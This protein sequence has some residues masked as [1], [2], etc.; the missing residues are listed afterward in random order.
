MKVSVIIGITGSNSPL[1]RTRESVRA[2]VESARQKGIGCSVTEVPANLRDEAI[3]ASSGKYVAWVEGGDLISSN[4][5]TECVELLE[6]REGE[7]LLLHPE[8]SILFGQ[9]PPQ[10]LRSAD[11]ESPEFNPAG[12]VWSN[13]WSPLVLAPRALLLE[14]PFPKREPGFGHETWHWNCELLHR[15]VIHKAVPRTAHFLRLES[16]HVGELLSRDWRVPVLPSEYFA[17]PLAA[18]RPRE[19][20]KPFAGSSW[21]APLCKESS[22]PLPSDEVHFDDGALTPIFQRFLDEIGPNPDCLFVMHQLRRG[23]AELEAI[24]HAR[25]FREVNPGSRV[26]FVTTELSAPDW[27]DHLPRGMKVLPLGRETIQYFTG[28][29]QLR[30]LLKLLLQAR[31][32]AIH[33]KHSWQCWDLFR[34]CNTALRRFSRLFAS[35]YCIEYAQDGTKT[36]FAYSHLAYCTPAL[37]AVFCDNQSLADHLRDE[38]G[39][40]SARVLR[41]PVF[42]SSLGLGQGPG[43]P[44][45][46]GRKLRVLWASRLARQKNLGVLFTVADHMREDEFHVYGEFSE[47]PDHEL[48]RRLSSTPN[49]HYFGG[50]DGLDSIATESF[51]AFL[52][53][54]SWDGLPNILLEAGVKGLPVLAPSVGGIPELIGKTTGFPVDVPADYI[55]ALEEIRAN[56]TE[57]DRRSRNLAALISSRHSARAFAEILQST[58]GYLS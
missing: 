24:A 15:G 12:L 47:P 18:R 22:A 39:V 9:G 25:A 43:V 3:L 20:A 6:R 27:I 1:D 16:D 4:W 51:D 44:R 29:D 58:P 23:G 40:T 38:C 11:S 54:S 37:E 36:S 17:S 13:Y 45:G 32:R 8:V 30:L 2:S 41:F 56:P 46:A 28:E 48:R 31:P 50:F 35:L 10:L 57:A 14:H 5:I 53:T 19:T 34:D 55:R 42:A 21:L 52:Y 26:H 49:L 33:V 7:P